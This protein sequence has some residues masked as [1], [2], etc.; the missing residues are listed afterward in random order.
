MVAAHS[1]SVH[2]VVAADIR[3]TEFVAL[4]VV[5]AVGLVAPVLEAVLVQATK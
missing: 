5:A 1:H 4:A 2:V 3:D